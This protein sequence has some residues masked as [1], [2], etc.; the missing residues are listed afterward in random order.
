MDPDSASSSAGRE[1]QGM[2]RRG[3]ERRVVTT[4]FCDLVAFTALSER[5]DPEL[6]D[7]FLHRYYAAARRVVESYGGTVE[8]FI[9][10][11]VVAVFGVPT[12]HE[13]D[14]ERA[15]RAGLR[16]VDEIDAL[17][18]IGGQ[19]VEVRVGV[20]TGE[21]LVRL[22]VDPGSGEGFLT[23][24]AVNVAARLQS[25]APPMAV[26]V[27]EATHTATEKVFSFDACHAVT[28]KGK[29]QPLR[30]WI[31]TAP[32]ARTGSELRTFSSA[33]VG[34]EEELASLEEL[35]D[36]VA[37]ERSP[38]FA[39][40]VG[41][42]GIGKSR[43]LAELARRLDD[44]PTLVTWRQGRCL[45]F[46]SNVTFWA[47]S[48]IVRAAAGIL[49]SDGVARSEARLETVLPE[50]E[51]RDR[52][53][54]RLRPLLGLE[55]QEASRE[56]NFSAW[57][58]FLESLAAS[59]PAVIVVEDLHWADEAML[60]FMDYLAQSSAGVPL[61]VLTTARPQVLELA[62][63]GAGFVA[64]AKHVPLGPLSGEETAAAR[65]VPASAPS[66]CPPTCR[67]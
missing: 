23:G 45:P 53:R 42:P 10:D 32:L 37:K 54:A 20:N 61:L 11:A 60:A 63:P 21:A 46:G 56:E 7:A 40:I 47:L 57:R 17:P 50:G 49:E 3:E 26:A 25:A 36:E 64:A 66:R 55:A 29:S 15:V 67:R 9:G 4:L 62:G 48:E 59:G 44:Q 30:A 8:K 12:L 16:L 38:R 18:G 31:A 5:N 43:L 24:D 33:F 1:P 13:D 2:P 19:A 52:M 14:P 41:E 58:E 22:D 65:P 28:L 27:G 51:D 34:R 35:L 6:I 39:L